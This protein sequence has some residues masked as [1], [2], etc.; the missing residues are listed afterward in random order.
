MK[1]VTNRLNCA[2]SNV[3]QMNTSAKLDEILQIGQPT[4]VKT[5][6]GYARGSHTKRNTMI[7]R[8]I[9]IWKVC[10]DGQNMISANM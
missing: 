6:H 1:D 8:D 5:G 4:Y 7:S 9:K 3:T 10:S 2:D